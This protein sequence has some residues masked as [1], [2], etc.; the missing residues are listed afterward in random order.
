MELESGLHQADRIGTTPTR[1]DNGPRQPKS[2]RGGMTV[3]EQP[4]S[5]RKLNTKHTPLH[6]LEHWSNYSLLYISFLQRVE[7][8]IPIN[9]TRS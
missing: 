3:S 4:V 8:A 7:N 1:Y 6:Q 2:S 5:T 9:W